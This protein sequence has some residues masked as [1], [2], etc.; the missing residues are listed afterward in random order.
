MARRRTASRDA[1]RLWQALDIERG[2]EDA[3]E[4]VLRE[5]LDALE[6]ARLDDVARLGRRTRRAGPAAGALPSTRRPLRAPAPA[7]DGTATRCWPRCA[8]AQPGAARLLADW[9][10]RRP[11]PRRVSAGAARARRRSASAKRSSRRE[12]HLVTAQGVSFFAP[13]SEL[14]GVLARQRELDELA[15]AIADGERGRRRP[16]ALRSTR[17][18]ARAR[19][20]A[21]DAITPRAWRSRRSSGACH[22]LELE[23]LQLRQAAEA[24][25]Q[26]RAQIDKEAAEISA[27][28]SRRA[29]RSATAL[30]REIA[31]AAIAAARR[32]RRA[33]RRAPRAQRGRSRA[34]AGP[35]ARARRRARG[36]GSGLRRAQLPRPARR[37]RAPARSAGGAGRAAARAARA[38]SRPSARR[39]T[40]RRSRRRCSDSSARAA[41]PSRRSPPRATG[42]KALA[43]ELRAARRGAARRRAEARTGARED[44]GHAAEGA[45]GGARRAAVRRA[46]RRGAGRPRRAAGRAEG[47][48]QHSRAARPRSSGC[49]TAIAELG[50]V[51]LAALDE[52]AQASERKEYLDRA[53]RRPHRGDGHARDGDPPDRPRVARA[54]AADVRQRQR[55]LRQAVSR[56]SSAAARRGSC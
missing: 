41:R 20:R 49:S 19:R 2:W 32:K 4:A 15:H 27:Q 28:R 43:A 37:A 54:A 25:A 23:L 24:A 35:R 31:D 52:L 38:S 26:R 48:G 36:A 5:R 3:L 45:G 8:Q 21:A 18:E 46:A 29:R 13:D 10:A 50:A 55:E 56:R 33:R 39:S 17:V 12:G 9:L 16:R 7:A 34:G 22:D 44:P 51:N 30:A 40:G 11:L 14:H 42:S 6:L 47:L 53:G 1:R